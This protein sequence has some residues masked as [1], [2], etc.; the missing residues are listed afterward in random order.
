MPPDFFSYKLKYCLECFDDAENL[1]V[2]QVLEM[3]KC[4][5]F[6]IGIQFENFSM[7]TV[8]LTL[9]QNKP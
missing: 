6:L 7:K 9:K 5:S 1:T 8:C 2:K 4:Q 3:Q